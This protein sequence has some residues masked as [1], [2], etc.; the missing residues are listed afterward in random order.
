MRLPR[1]FRWK[2]WR[3]YVYPMLGKMIPSELC[4]FSL[5]EADGKIQMDPFRRPLE[6]L[7]P[8]SIKRNTSFSSIHS[9]KSV[10]D[11]QKQLDML[12]HSDTPLNLED[13]ATIVSGSVS[14]VGEDSSEEES[15]Y[16]GRMMQK[17]RD[18][19]EGGYVIGENKMIRPEDLAQKKK[20]LQDRLQERSASYKRTKEMSEKKI[21]ME[22]DST[23]ME[24]FQLFRVS[25]DLWKRMGGG[26]SNSNTPPPIGDTTS[27]HKSGAYTAK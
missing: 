16:E 3:S 23:D 19:T 6:I 11:V 18:S 10:D 2:D 12:Q 15:V 20:L 7:I 5:E 9:G 4:S 17:I 24:G 26:K 13:I 27:G 14:L 1:M 22:S 25:Y 8:V 21:A